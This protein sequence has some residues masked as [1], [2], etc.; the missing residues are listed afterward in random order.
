MFITLKEMFLVL[1]QCTVRYITGLLE[2]ILPL[3]G[4]RCDA[5][6][7]TQLVIFLED[8]RDDDLHL[9]CVKPQTR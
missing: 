2:V 5:T 8:I 3:P 9:M 7:R 6:T 4:K 1:G